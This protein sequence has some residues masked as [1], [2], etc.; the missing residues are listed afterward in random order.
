MVA[1]ACTLPPSFT[2]THPIKLMT[3]SARATLTLLEIL[4]ITKE[5]DDYRGS[6]EDSVDQDGVG[7]VIMDRTTHRGTRVWVMN[8]SHP[9]PTILMLP[10]D[11]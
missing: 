7:N 3:A 9:E 2:R 6:E 11:Y 8:R 4:W 5:W 10:E 1:T